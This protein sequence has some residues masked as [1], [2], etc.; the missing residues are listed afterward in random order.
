MD[1]NSTKQFLRISLLIIGFQFT[2][3]QKSYS[4]EIF[5]AP[6][7]R[8]YD[9]QDARLISSIVQD[10]RG[11]IYLTTSRG[12]IAYDGVDFE[13]IKTGFSGIAKLIKDAQGDIY[14]ATNQDFLKAEV[15]SIG[16]IV[17]KSLFPADS[18]KVSIG[19]TTLLT[20]SKYVYCIGDAGIYEYSIKDQKLNHYP[21]K[22]T[23]GF[24][25]DDKLWVTK[26]GTQLVV[27]NE[28][29]VS[30]APFQDEIN[31]V[32]NGGGLTSLSL[33]F[34]NNENLLFSNSNKKLF[35]YSGVHPSLRELSNFNVPVTGIGASATWS[36]NDHL[37]GTTFYGVLLIDSVGNVKYNYNVKTGLV[38]NFVGSLMVDRSKNIWIGMYSFGKSIVKTESAN[39]L[40]LWPKTGLSW[41]LAKFNGRVYIA[42]R[43]NLFEINPTSNEI[44]TMFENSRQIRSVITFKHQNQERLLA[45]VLPDN[46]VFEFSKDQSNPKIIYQGKRLTYIRQSKTNPNRLYICDNNQLGYL[47]FNGHTWKYNSIP[48][49][50]TS[51]YLVE[52]KEGSLWVSNGPKTALIRIIPKN[53]ND[54][55]E[56][57]EE[58]TYTQEDGLPKVYFYPM[59]LGENDLLFLSDTGV[60][61]FN[62]GTKKFK[63]WRGLGKF[64]N[65]LLNEGIAN[66]FKNQFDGSFYLQ[67]DSDHNFDIYQIKPMPNGDTI[68]VTKPF[69]R[70]IPQLGLVDA[71][72][73]LPEEN[74]NIWMGGSTFV[75]RYNAKEDRKNYEDDFLCL[76][77]KVTLNDSILFAGNLPKTQLSQLKPTLLYD[78]G[79]LT[80]RYAAPFYDSEERT[81]Y[82]YKLE[83]LDNTWSPWQK[84][85]QREFQHIS[86]GDY[87]F[88]V[89]AKNIYGKESNVAS[90][91]FTVLPPWYRTW[92]AYVIYVLLFGI[93]VIGLVRWRT[94]SLQRKKRELEEI[95]EE[96]TQELKDTNQQ[97][98]ITNQELE[99]SQ[100]ELRQSND[101][102][103]ATNEYLKKTQRQLVESEKMA[104]L[105]QLTAGIAHEINNPINFISGGVQAINTVTQE[106]LESNERTPEKLE[107]TIRDIQD[108]MASIN[109][110][111]N[112]TA[113]IIASLK[114]FTSP[115]EVIDTYIDVKECVENSIVLLRRKLLDHEIQLTTHYD[116][117]AQVLANSSQLSQVIINLL[118]NAI[119]ALKD[120]SGPRRIE[121]KTY[122]QGR[123][124]LILVKDNG[125]GID[126]SD[127]AHIFEPFFTT[128]EVG[129]GVGLGLS[130]SYS[131]IEKHKGKITCVSTIRKGTE[132]TVS[133]P[134]PD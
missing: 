73:F 102:L 79:R 32:T 133:L 104:S 41:E 69:K 134:I 105:G 67:Q 64:G 8:V 96:K 93:Y 121:V 24:I 36:K 19:V 76:I 47:L 129:S 57:K 81:L 98:L 18:T 84:G 85:T 107:S 89:K 28:G 101:E 74:G 37:L 83:G 17:F 33:P 9:N 95:V 44:R 71:F 45:A 59:L 20:S 75:V 27:L 56:I 46:A 51:V 103:H 3:C 7:M 97:L 127:I 124:L 16:K 125:L 120:V 55:F 118:D 30:P 12:V 49:T 61:E 94:S 23:G 90:Y 110:G 31:K 117:K 6:P 34:T 2:L 114:T 122:E 21:S 22:F 100:E 58:V 14:L 29:K 113:G 116:H 70:F 109:N 60:L 10:D 52:D 115:S 106:F 111:V 78:S 86:E 39:D 63:P 126:E 131:I 108:L 15:D 112:R 80:I 87:V 11:I 68:V 4:Q 132:F 5:G 65:N 72:A 40:Q 53:N 91:S 99:T 128:K 62:N 130:I 26:A 38:D 54:I 50:F 88:L 1:R 35:A 66:I 48:T 92:W 77:R 119:H 82:S 13:T 43:Q 42:S 123:E 25:K